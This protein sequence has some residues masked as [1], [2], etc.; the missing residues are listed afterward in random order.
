MSRRRKAK[1][2]K[3]RTSGRGGRKDEAT[4]V[5]TSSPSPLVWSRRVRS[6]RF[7]VASP[8]LKGLAA[9]A[10][11]AAF[12]LQMQEASR[13]RTHTRAGRDRRLKKRKKATDDDDD[14]DDNDDR[15]EVEDAGE[16]P[17]SH[18]RSHRVIKCVKEYT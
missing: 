18:C 8:R 6:R 17:V 11:A 3:Q 14:D 7:H 2:Q 4:S 12:V 10:R 5:E 13:P 16:R 1:V 15:R 9:D